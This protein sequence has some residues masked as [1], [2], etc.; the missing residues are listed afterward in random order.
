HL[1]GA[2]Q[3]HAVLERVHLRA[4]LHL[5]VGQQDRGG[6]RHVGPHPRRHLFL[7][8]AD[9]RRSARLGPD[10]RDLRPLPRLLRLRAHRGRGQ[11][12]AAPPVGGRG[13]VAGVAPKRW[14]AARRREVGLAYLLLAPALL[15]LGG[16]LAFPLAWE[17]RASLTSLS[18]LQDGGAVF[19]GLE[20]YRRPLPG[21][22]FWLPAPL[23]PLHPPL[24]R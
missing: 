23:T 17:I 24:T 10:R 11:G 21:S 5:A 14:S 8:L 19:V 13:M 12:I 2:V 7:G 1:R 20:N 22:P 15:L 6:R 16:V 3:L 18:P 4:D 9:G